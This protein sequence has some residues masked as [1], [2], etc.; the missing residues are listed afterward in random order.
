RLRPTRVALLYSIS[1]DYWQPFGYA[2]MLDRR[3]VYLALVHDQFLVDMVTEEDVMAGRL[4]D[5]RILYSADPCIS[6]D[7]SKAIVEWVRGGGTLVATCAAGGRN[8]FGEPS[9]QLAEAFGIA[10][11]V[12]VDC[13]PGE[14]R[15]RGKLNDI[16]YRDKMKTAGGEFGVV[17]VRAT[18]QPR[19]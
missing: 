5:Y 7:A 10:P 12:T 15:M 13:Q 4:A 2:H 19:G 9:A 6:T 8:E 17:G 14:Y 3:G 16:A 1:S 11:E 18:I